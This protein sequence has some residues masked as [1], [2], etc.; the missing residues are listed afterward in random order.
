MYRV[1]GA[2]VAVSMLVAPASASLSR[3]AP[4]DGPDDRR[5]LRAA[6][7]PPKAEPKPQADA[8]DSPELELTADTQV[9][10]DGKRCEYK[11]VPAT[12]AITRIDLA[13]NKK[14]V[15]RIEFE[16]KK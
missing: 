13:K 14:T 12:A 10:L 15:V 7:L 11:D 9:Y 6:V 2:V 1:A 16:S 3:L 5:E 4:I 8:G